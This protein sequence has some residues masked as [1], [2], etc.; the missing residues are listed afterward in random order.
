EYTGTTVKEMIADCE[1]QYGWHFMYLAASDEAFG[2]YETIG[3][4]RASCFQ[5]K[6]TPESWGAAQKNVS[7]MLID[8]RDDGARSQQNLL[9]D[10]GD[11][12]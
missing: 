12:E 2:Q 6:A 10:K 9:F 8:Y 1:S 4:D 7:Q 11:E 5:I 3:I